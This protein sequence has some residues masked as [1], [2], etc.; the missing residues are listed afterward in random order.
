MATLR[1]TLIFWTPR[2]LSILYVLFLSLFSLD[3]FEAGGGFG[4]IALG[5]LIH[6]LPSLALLSLTI[7]AWRKDLIGT[8]TFG[9]AG[10]LYLAMT[11]YNQ[12]PWPQILIW[13]L[14]IAAPA[15]LT[16]FLYYRSGR[17]KRDEEE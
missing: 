15:F 1:R 13:N 5:L 10:L 8:L 16:A 6:N 9:I 12:V 17:L 14:T 7:L 4:A 3:V 2:V 11:I